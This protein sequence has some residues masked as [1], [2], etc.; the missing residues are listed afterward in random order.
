MGIAACASSAKTLR[1]PIMAGKAITLRI[2][3]K[4]KKAAL[5]AQL[6]ET[7]EG[8]AKNCHL[9]SNAYLI[10]TEAKNSGDN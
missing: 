6:P 5:A 10:S 2:E 3:L 8:N 7:N 4:R 1:V 9:I